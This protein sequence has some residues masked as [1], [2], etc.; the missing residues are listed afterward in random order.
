MIS[1]S[2]PAAPAAVA[3]RLLA[4]GALAA[5]V[6]GAAAGCSS[7]GDTSGTEGAA[8]TGGGMTSEVATAQ[9]AAQ[10][11]AEGTGETGAPTSSSGAS[12]TSASE[13]SMPTPTEV[14]YE[15]TGQWD[16][17]PEASGPQGDGTPFAIAVRVEKG[18]PIEID[19]TAEFVMETLRDERGWQKLDGVAFELVTDESQAAVRVSVASPQ[20]TDRICAGL[21]TN[22]YTSCREG[23]QVALNANRWLGATEDF[24][25]LTVYRQYVINHEVGHALGHRHE[26]CPAPGSPAPLMQQQTLG[27]QGC[28][29]NP[30]P[31]VA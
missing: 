16:Y 1:R 8:E 5:A 31:S 26:Y 7:E 17:A 10:A 19:D 21:T 24:D 2:A 14:P 6:A 20:T 12:T 27:L 22:G 25:D 28:T 23:N 13:T 11:G 9:A 15:G 29:V 30:W 18:L 4:A 3:R